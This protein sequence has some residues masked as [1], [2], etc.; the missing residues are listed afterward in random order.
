MTFNQKRKLN[1]KNG[2][3]LLFID[4]RDK[5]LEIYGPENN[6]G[7]YQALDKFDRDL[8]AIARNQGFY[9]S[10]VWN[11]NIEEAK[12]KIYKLWEDYYG[13][14]EETRAQYCDQAD[15]YSVDGRTGGGEL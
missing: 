4:F 10:E 12:E 5:D 8:I 1:R 13:T 11:D 14:N 9:K 7:L 15:R 6:V 3:K 2:R